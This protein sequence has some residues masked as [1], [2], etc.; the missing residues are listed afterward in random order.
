MSH[1]GGLLKEGKADG[2]GASNDGIKTV[3]AAAD[4][5][6][7][8]NGLE[9]K[10]RVQA[11]QRNINAQMATAIQLMSDGAR[12]YDALLTQELRESGRAHS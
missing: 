4:S 10:R 9:R 8:V 3:Q 5:W 12:R 6:A 1:P 7:D 11:A 2:A